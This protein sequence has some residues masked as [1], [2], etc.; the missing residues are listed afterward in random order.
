LINEESLSSDCRGHASYESLLITQILSL[1]NSYLGKSSTVKEAIAAIKKEVEEEK[2]PKFKYV[3]F[4]GMKINS[5]RQVFSAIWAQIS[6]EKKPATRA[7]ENIEKEIE[8]GEM[9]PIIM[10]A[11]ELGKLSRIS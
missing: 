10:M 11:D 3:E 1:L 7:A 6:G 8:S 4:N 2:L 5:P 9:E